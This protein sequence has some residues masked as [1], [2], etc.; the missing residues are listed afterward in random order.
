MFAENRAFEM[1]RFA[2][3]GRPVGHIRRSVKQTPSLS[4]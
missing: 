1:R 2:W 3:F 4:E